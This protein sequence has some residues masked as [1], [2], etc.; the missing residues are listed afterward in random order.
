MEH[1]STIT[2]GRG[3]PVISDSAGKKA[4]LMMMNARIRVTMS[5]AQLSSFRNVH[6]FL[7]YLLISIV[8]ENK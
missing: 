1:D 8:G 4:N 6:N 7:R 2:S 3:V 5:D